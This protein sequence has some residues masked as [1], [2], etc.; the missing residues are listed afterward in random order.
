MTYADP[1]TLQQKR[2]GRTVRARIREVVTAAGCSHFRRAA[3]TPFKLVYEA[4]RHVLKE[5]RG[6]WVHADNRQY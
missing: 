6:Y 3:E 2:Q 4:R 5:G 1:H